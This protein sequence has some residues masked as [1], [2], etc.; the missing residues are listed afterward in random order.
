MTFNH[1]LAYKSSFWA[2]N[3]HGTHT[4][5]MTLTVIENIA[6]KLVY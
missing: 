4:L 1:N 3:L 6:H 5:N 2:D